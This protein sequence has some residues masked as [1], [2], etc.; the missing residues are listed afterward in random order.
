MTLLSH[1]YTVAAAFSKN[2]ISS[3]R[4]EILPLLLWQKQQGL[5]LLVAVMHNESIQV[6]P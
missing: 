3:N 2:V 6:H 4:N 1:I 5:F